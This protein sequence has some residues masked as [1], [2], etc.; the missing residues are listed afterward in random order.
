MLRFALTARAFLGLL[1]AAAWVNA[2]TSKVAPG[3]F[4][5]LA[6]LG[7]G[8][9][10]VSTAAANS[11][12]GNDFP[13]IAAIIGLIS[14]ATFTIT[15]IVLWSIRTSERR[16]AKEIQRFDNQLSA[17]GAQASITPW[18]TPRTQMAGTWGGPT[19]VYAVL[20]RG[21]LRIPL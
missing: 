4:T 14:G 13:K 11:D 1:P 6:V 20:R 7:L 15:Y 19:S 8:V 2:N 3:I 5:G 9:G 18:F 21:F 16:Q 12:P 10:L 17:L